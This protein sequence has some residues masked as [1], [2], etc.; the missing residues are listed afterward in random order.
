MKKLILTL[1]FALISPTLLAETGVAP[2][3]QSSCY[4]DTVALDQ[5][6]R[7]ESKTLT[8]DDGDFKVV[9]DLAT[10][11]QWAY[12]PYGTDVT[13]EG[14]CSGTQF[15]L[16]RSWSTNYPIEI[17]KVVN[18]ENTRLGEYVDPWR[19]ANFNESLSIFNKSCTPN[20]YTNFY[21]A[22][23]TQAELDE[24]LALRVADHHQATMEW[25]LMGL[26]TFATETP[27]KNVKRIHSINYGYSTDVLGQ[28]SGGSIRL[29]REIPVSK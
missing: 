3:L 5:T 12:C 29:V 7:F 25:V 16:P 6:G 26:F 17:S 14:T 24:M 1:P 27:N 20:V 23:H 18:K 21:Y 9:N 28:L 19:V 15:V 10:G 11:L 8:S 4:T 13:A 22:Q 2:I